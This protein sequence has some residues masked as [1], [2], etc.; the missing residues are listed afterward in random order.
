MEF[1]VCLGFLFYHDF[2]QEWCD[3]VM[4]KS[5]LHRV[6][7]RRHR[8]S[9]RGLGEI[10]ALFAVKILFEVCLTMTRMV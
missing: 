5:K 2:Y 6:T 8:V 1:C 4:V 9:Q 10:F 3:C 7:Q